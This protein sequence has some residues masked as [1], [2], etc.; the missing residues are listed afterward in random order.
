[1]AAG[2]LGL[3]QRTRRRRAALRPAGRG[4]PLLDDATLATERALA[5]SA[6]TSLTHSTFAVM[7]T[8]AQRSLVP[9][10][11][12]V[13]PEVMMITDAG[14]DVVLGGPEPSMP[15]G[16]TARGDAHRLS[17]ETAAAVASPSD[18]TWAAPALATIADGIVVNLEAIGVLTV[19]GADEP[20]AALVRSML[21]DLAVGPARRQ[22]DIRTSHD[23]AGASLHPGVRVD[24]V[25]VVVEEITRWLDQLDLTLAAAGAPN[26]YALRTT[27]GTEAITPIVLFVSEQDRAAVQPVLDRARRGRYPLGVVVSSSDTSIATGANPVTGTVATIDGTG[28]LHLTPHGHRAPAQ[29]L[30]LDAIERVTHLINQLTTAPLRHEANQDRA[31]ATAWMSEQADVSTLD[32][33]AGPSAADD[34][35]FEAAEVTYLPGSDAEPAGDADPGAGLSPID[36]RVLGTVEIDGV[37]TPLTPPQASLLTHLC[38][39]GPVTGPQLEQ[40]LWPHREPS[41]ARLA[42]LVDDVRRAIGRERL[43]ESTDGRFHAVGITSDLTR[44]REHLAAAGDARGLTRRRALV[45]ALSEIRGVPFAAVDDRS[46]QWVQDHHLGTASQASRLIADTALELAEESTLAGDLDTARTALDQA[47]LADPTSRA[48]AEARVEL[49]ESPA[50]AD[51][52]SARWEDDFEQQTE[53]NALVELATVEIDHTEVPRVGS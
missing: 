25:E 4:L 1:M 7:Q 2:L 12:M 46:W 53:R 28:L 19:Q 8:L 18:V 24:P 48:V 9:G 22:L 13:Q 52:V 21:H 41:P 32:A 45:S 27:E 38:I 15:N 30:S 39:I 17:H 49:S 16:W 23:V 14:F 36:I 5:A 43:P 29:A 10:E 26:A 34:A 20:V 44:A 50:M 42:S 11:P 35:A 3:A 51:R 40:A 31:L 6:D 37:R 47:A 33:P